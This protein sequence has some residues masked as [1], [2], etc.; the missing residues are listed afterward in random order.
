MK[1]MGFTHRRKRKSSEP[2]LKFRYAAR[3][4]SKD[5]TGVIFID[6]DQKFR[7]VAWTEVVE[8]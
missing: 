1:G 8:L 4:G 2:Y 3:V 7:Y 5:A 6:Q